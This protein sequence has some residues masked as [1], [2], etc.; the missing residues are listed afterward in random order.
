MYPT[1]AVNQQ[2]P[3]YY[4][5][6][7]YPYPYAVPQ[8]MYMPYSI[9][10]APPVTPQYQPSVQY[11]EEEIDKLLEKGY[12]IEQARSIYMQ[13]SRSSDNVSDNLSSFC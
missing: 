8:H 6:G 3:V 11:D 10:M 9:P 5:Q 4:P 7:S 2:Y 13:R 12:T 1:T